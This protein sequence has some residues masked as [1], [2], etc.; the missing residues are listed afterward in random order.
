MMECANI[1]PNSGIVVTTDLGAKNYIHPPFK[2]EVADRLF[3]L[4]MNKSYG[5]QDIDCEGPLYKEVSFEN[6]KAIVS[7]K[8]DK[9]GLY[10]PHN[11]LSGFLI[12]GEDRVV[13]AA[14]ARISGNKNAIQVWSD[15][16]KTPV[17]VR[18][19]WS[20][21]IEAYIYDNSML[22]ASSFRTDNW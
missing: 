1:I 5:Y 22:P 20:N 16:V 19:G 3:Y 21:Y 12:A 18:Y 2:K 13:Y 11:D 17:A 10:S 6:N 9:G 14:K 15:S 4:A 8:E 7:F